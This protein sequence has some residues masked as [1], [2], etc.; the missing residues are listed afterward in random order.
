MLK[1]G[2]LAHALGQVRRVEVRQTNRQVLGEAWRE[3]RNVEVG[4]WQAAAWLV[5]CVDLLNIVGGV[6]VAAVAATAAVLVGLAGRGS[7]SLPA[8]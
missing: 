5:V 6:V 3:A 1:H 7:V 2:Q 4:N 8:A